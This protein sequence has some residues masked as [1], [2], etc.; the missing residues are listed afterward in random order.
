MAS[1][2]LLINTFEKYSII[3]IV[4]LIHSCV[5]NL[6]VCVISKNATFLNRKYYIIC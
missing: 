3:K 5:G 1:L 6:C 4:D 2:L